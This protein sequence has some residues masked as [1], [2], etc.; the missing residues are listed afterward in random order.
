MV[1]RTLSELYNENNDKNKNKD[2]A[3]VVDSQHVF[4]GAGYHNC[5]KIN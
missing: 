5:N 2:T 4:N 1:Q 3:N